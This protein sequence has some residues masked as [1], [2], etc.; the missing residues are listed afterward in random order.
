MP[1]YSDEV[2]KNIEE[3]FRLFLIDK[4]Q[5][6][7]IAKLISIIAPNN[8]LQTQ[9][10]H[11]AYHGLLRRIMILNRCVENIFNVRDFYLET[12]PSDDELSDI[13]INLQCFIINLYGA[14]ENLAWIYAIYINF[15]GK[16]FDISFFAKQK[17]LL[18]TLPENI[19][20]SFIGD[21]KWLEYIK[22]IRDLLAHQEPLYIPPYCVIMEQKD[23]WQVLEEKKWKIESNF[24]KELLEISKK[25][26]SSHEPTTVNKIKAELQKLDEFEIQKNEIISKINAEQS[27]Y[28][29][30]RP[31]LVANTNTIDPL[32][33]QFY[34][35]TLVDI[36]TI[37][38]KV[39]LI[40][41]YM[42]EIKK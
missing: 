24:I 38:E 8:T 26:N 3:E 5:Y 13:I 27:Q 10:Y 15:K 4:S 40:L 21:G 41:K 31:M 20:K 29:I 25:R 33:I 11:F 37:Y 19:K 32:Y 34:P 1:F 23:K 12:V 30:F 14:L 42:V 16:N 17:K 18:N 2:I 39:L 6:A 7:K 28:I 35:Q 22:K 9:L 36:K